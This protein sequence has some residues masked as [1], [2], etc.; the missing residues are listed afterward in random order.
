MPNIGDRVIQCLE[1]LSPRPRHRDVAELVGMTPDA[2]S[3]ALNGKRQFA[4]IEL[5]RLAEE[6]GA[7]LHWLI[8]GQED[9][10]RIKVAARHHFDH[11]NGRRTIPGRADDEPTLAD[12]ALAYRQAYPEPA[13]LA[14]WPESPAS[15]REALG[16]EFVRPFADRL[17]RRLGIDVVRVAELSTAYSFTIGGRAVIAMPATGNWFRENWDIAHELGHLVM[18]HHD[19][20]LTETDEDQHEAAANAFAAELLLPTEYL[21]SVHWDSLED[22][23][24]AALVWSW[25]VSTDALCR[26]L[27]AF[28]GHTPKCVARW[29]GHP[30]QRLL[31]GHLRIESELDEITTRMDAAAQRRFPLGIQ[32]AHLEL[33]AAGAISAGTLAWMLGIDADALEVD[34]PEIPEVNVDDLAIAL[35]L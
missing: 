2:F 16:P 35:G 13:K 14:D 7:D 20:G 28:L 32:E 12:I 23:D 9:P 5:A 29:A 19:D 33:V 8:T 18:R 27:Y 3:R 17:E 10:N 21:K 25:G 22:D 26:R 34:S 31:R 1:A 6:I 30:T 11:S 24:L 4:S 15:V